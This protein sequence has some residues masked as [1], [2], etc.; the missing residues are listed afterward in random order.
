MSRNLA[1]RSAKVCI[2]GGINSGWEL[3]GREKIC[4]WSGRPGTQEGEH[5]SRGCSCRE[6]SSSMT[7]VAIWSRTIISPVYSALVSP[8]LQCPA[9]IS[10]VL[11]PQREISKG[12]YP[13]QSYQ[14]IWELVHSRN[15]ERLRSL[16]C[17]TWRN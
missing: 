10:P 16:V 9:F 6:N 7:V 3:A 2:L 13:A 5:E 14:D 17:L 1:K 8:Y 15:K 11:H 12:W 4:E